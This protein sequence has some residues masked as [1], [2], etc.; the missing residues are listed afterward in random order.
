M[1]THPTTWRNPIWLYLCNS[2]PVRETKQA[3]FS[4]QRNETESSNQAQKA[5]RSR[6]NLAESM[7]RITRLRGRGWGWGWEKGGWREAYIENGGWWWDNCEGKSTRKKG[8][9]L[10]FEG[11]LSVRAMSVK[12]AYSP[13]ARANGTHL[14]WG[15]GWRHPNQ[16]FLAFLLPCNQLPCRFLQQLF[17]AAKREPMQPTWLG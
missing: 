4:N 12:T 9:G 13:Q 7:N 2:L 15:R 16:A 10:N 3:M 5:E 14:A 11:G 1:K 6:C 17:H 8:G